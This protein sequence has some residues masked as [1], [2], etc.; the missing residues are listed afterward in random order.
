MTKVCDLPNEFSITKMWTM[1]KRTDL[2][3]SLSEHLTRN[4]ITL[5]IVDP[6]D[7]RHLP[8]QLIGE[9][10]TLHKAAYLPRRMASNIRRDIHRQ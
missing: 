2:M 1:G 7:Q 8:S 10:F 4:M 3:E 6:A 9:R 5:R